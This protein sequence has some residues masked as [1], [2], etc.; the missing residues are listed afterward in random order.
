MD[1]LRDNIT[2]LDLTDVK[3]TYTTM[4]IIVTILIRHNFAAATF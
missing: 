1:L 2:S 3:T 4:A